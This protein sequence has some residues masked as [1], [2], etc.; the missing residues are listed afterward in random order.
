M[1]LNAGLPGLQDMQD[2]EIDYF[3]LVFKRC[4]IPNRQFQHTDTPETPPNSPP[5]YRGGGEF[6]R[7]VSPKSAKTEYFGVLCLNA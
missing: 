1:R 2:I 5:T 7:G 6:R 4:V 3:I